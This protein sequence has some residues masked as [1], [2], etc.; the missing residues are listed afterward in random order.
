M[1]LEFTTPRSKVTYST[2]WAN[3]APLELFFKNYSHHTHF[4][5][6]RYS[7]QIYS[8][9]ALE[10]FILCLRSLNKRLACAFFLKVDFMP[11]LGFNS[12]PWDWESYALL[13]EPGRRPSS[14]NF[15]R[16]FQY[17]FSVSFMVNFGFDN[18]R[19][20]CFRGRAYTF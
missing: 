11:K 12:R 15:Y 8:S 4:E 13:T 16:K 14:S 7:F 17:I 18:Y 9:K 2:N 5:H 3:Q 20:E 6:V 1:G 19:S 10:I